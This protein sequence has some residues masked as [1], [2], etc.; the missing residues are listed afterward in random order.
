MTTARLIFLLIILMVPSINYTQTRSVTA[1]GNKSW[2]KFYRA[3]SAAVKTRDSSSLKRMMPSER[4][5][6]SEGWCTKDQMVQLIDQSRLWE[7]M[8]KA[9]KSGTRLYRPSDE[10]KGR[11]AK[12]TKE[13]LGCIF[14]FRADGKWYFVGLMGH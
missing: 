6:C 7:S 11:P 8:E 2:P 3:F 10:D 13:D 12:L 5:S 4:I 14:V 9:M 1:A